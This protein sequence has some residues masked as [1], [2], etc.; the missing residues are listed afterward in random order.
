MA[1][2]HSVIVQRF[3]GVIYA[4]GSVGTLLGIAFYMRYLQHYTFRRLMFWAQVLKALSGVFDLALVTRVNQ[5][6]LIPDTVFAVIDEGISSVSTHYSLAYLDYFH[7][8]LTLYSG[9]CTNLMMAGN[10]K[11]EV[12]VAFS[13]VSETVPTG[14]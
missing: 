8:K 3:V 13:N 1:L 4:M 2:I 12:D 9:P 10:W 6:L 14:H 5:K 7:R 11:I